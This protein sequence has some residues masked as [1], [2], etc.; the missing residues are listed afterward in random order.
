LALA[1]AERAAAYPGSS[2]NIRP[3]PEWSFG[4]RGDNQIATRLAA[5]STHSSELG[6][7]RVA[8]EWSFGPTGDDEIARLAAASTQLFLELSLLVECRI[9]VERVIARLR[10]QH[11]NSRREMEIYA[12]FSLAV[13]QIEGSIELVRKAFSRTLDVAS[14][15]GGSACELQL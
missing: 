13:M 15:Q 2:V 4:R 6:N 8:K 10:D 5:I 3:A 1:K 7:I 12:S 11:K 9:W 14:I